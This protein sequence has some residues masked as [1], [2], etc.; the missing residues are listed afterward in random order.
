MTVNRYRRGYLG[1]LLLA[2]IAVGALRL[3]CTAPWLSV[4]AVQDSCCA[5]EL[6]P[7]SSC[8][9]SPTSL[10]RLGAELSTALLPTSIPKVEAAQNGLGLLV[11]VEPETR[12]GLQETVPYPPRGPPTSFATLNV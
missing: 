2:F 5:A 9:C 10:A 6:E 12:A 11:W 3:P 8:C 1:I 7:S 4:S